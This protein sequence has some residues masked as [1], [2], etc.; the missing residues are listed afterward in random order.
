ML[1]ELALLGDNGKERVALSAPDLLGLTVLQTLGRAIT[2]TLQTDN[3]S[4]AV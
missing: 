1:N 2:S 3:H 4:L